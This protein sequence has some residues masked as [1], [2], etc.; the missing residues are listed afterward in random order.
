MGRHATIFY[1]ICCI[2]NDAVSNHSRK[3]DLEM[4]D[5]GQHTF[6][7]CDH[8]VLDVSD[9]AAVGAEIEVRMR[10]M[11]GLYHTESHHNC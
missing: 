1:C 7:Y 8:T 2:F 10:N 3:T 11:I 4:S 6:P 9:A 5:R